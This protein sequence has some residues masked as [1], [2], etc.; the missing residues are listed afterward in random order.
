MSL[1]YPPTTITGALN[2]KKDIY[3]RYP[4]HAN[5]TYDDANGTLLTFKT[6]VSDSPYGN[7]EYKAF[8]NDWLQYTEGTSYGSNEWPA[9]G[10]F[11][12]SEG[13]TNTRLSYHN[14]SISMSTGSDMTNPLII[15]I[16]MPDHIKLT[17][18][19]MKNRPGFA[20]R[21]PKKWKLY[22]RRNCGTWTLIETRE[23]SS[24]S[25]GQTR[26]WNISPSEYYSD[27]RFDFLTAYNSS[28]QIYTIKLYG[29]PEQMTTPISFDRLGNLP[30]TR[31][32]IYNKATSSA[33]TLERGLKD[34]A[35]IENTTVMSLDLLQDPT[36][37]NGKFYV[38]NSGTHTEYFPS[39]FSTTP[40][41]FF[42]LEWEDWGSGNETRKN[43]V[44]TSVTTK[45]FTITNPQSNMDPIV[46][47]M[48][49][50]PGTGTIYGKNYK[51]EVVSSGNSWGTNRTFT[52]SS[53]MG[54]NP[55]AMYCVNSRNNGSNVY[56]TSLNAMPTSTQTTFCTGVNDEETVTNNQTVSSSEQLAY[57]VIQNSG[58]VT[59]KMY[60]WTG[61]EKSVAYDAHTTTTNGAALQNAICLGIV[62]NT[63]G[64]SSETFPSTPFTLG[65]D[66]S[67][68]EIGALENQTGNTNSEQDGIYEVSTGVRGSAYSGPTAVFDNNNSTLIQFGSYTGGSG[69]GQYTGS[70]DESGTGYLGG[71]VRIKMPIKVLLSQYSIT[72]GT[73]GNSNQ[74]PRNHA[75][76]GSN[77]NS[78]WT[79]LNNISGQTS[80]SNNQTKSWNISPGT[81]YQYYLYICNRIIKSNQHHLY[82]LSFV[83][84]GYPDNVASGNAGLTWPPANFNILGNHFDDQTEGR[85]IVTSSSV[86][87][88]SPTYME[89]YLAFNDSLGDRYLWYSNNNY[90]NGTYTGSS[91]ESGTGYL[92]EWLKIQ[93]PTATSLT[94]YTL[95]ADDTYF[96]KSPKDWKL[97]GSNDNSSWTAIDTQTSQT[98]TASESKNFTITSSSYLYFLFIFNKSASGSNVAVGYITFEGST[99]SGS[100]GSLTLYANRLTDKR[101]KWYIKEYVGRDGTH[102][103][104]TTLMLQMAGTITRTSKPL[105][106]LD[107]THL[108]AV[109]GVSANSQIDRWYNLSQRG[110]KYAVGRGS[111]KPTLKSD[112]NGYYVDFNYTGAYF[113][114]PCPITWKFADVD[115]VGTKGLTC[116]AVAQFNDTGSTT[117]DNFFDCCNPGTGGG[118]ASTETKNGSTYYKAIDEGTSNFGGTIYNNAQK[119]SG[120]VEL[121]PAS[122][123]QNGQIQWSGMNPGD[124]FYATFDTWTGS[125]S[126]ADAAWFYWGCTTRPTG[127]D[128]D[129]GGYLLAIDEYGTNEIQLEFNN[130]RLHTKVIGN[131]DDSAWHSW[132]V[133][134]KSNTIKVWRDTVL[135]FTK[136]DSSRTLS[137]LVGW[138]ARTGGKN[139]RH[140]VRNMKAW[141]SA[142]NGT[143]YINNGTPHTDRLLWGRTSTQ[144]KLQATDPSVQYDTTNSPA[145]VTHKVHTIRYNNPDKTSSIW[146][147]GTKLTPT[148][149]TQNTIDDRTTTRNVIGANADLSTSNMKLRELIVF[150]DILTDNQVSDINT[151]LGEKWGITF[152]TYPV[153][154]Q[155]YLVFRQTLGYLWTASQS[156]SLNSGDSSNDNYSILDTITDFQSTNG[157]YRLKYV[158]PANG[159]Y[160]D[161]RQTNNLTNAVQAGY[162]AVNVSHSTNGFNGL[163]PSG[164]TNKTRFDG[165][166]G[167]N[168]WYA[169]AAKQN[170][171][172]AFPGLD[173][174]HNVVEVYA[175][176][177]N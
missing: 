17:S 168:W 149:T 28:L 91:D 63:G 50:K 35:D 171:G 23:V 62:R 30:F 134:Y 5:V 119:K 123:S 77:D 157:T 121:T 7:G 22:G 70:E 136:V 129:S 151:S 14:T 42:T 40:G 156:L 87:H 174:V 89:P 51:C 86:K 85:Y 127:E 64:N 66:G 96:A 75:I 107:A 29:T 54:N 164:D 133:E 147:N 114:L 162:S 128:F 92:G 26:S 169:V 69:K 150:N 135:Q 46:H 88:L 140:L 94:Q 72:S 148:E 139:N 78:T 141:V 45:Y 108:N 109:Q 153:I 58:D 120:Y 55:Y 4:A 16:E 101:V 27:Y 159:N 57:L 98:Y 67:A 76:F 90:S 145:T 65:K 59:D 19:S 176:K 52:Y 132:I 68:R 122:N 74:A 165:T 12:K 154:G 106:H 31:T 99:G 73:N 61:T 9:N 43:L 112:S 130:S 25:S 84:E 10:P 33:I 21:S 155:W 116:F 18:Y 41:V 44:I 111:T 102:G 34:L 105:F 167:G 172:G 37:Y 104:E 79:S 95:Q 15:G 138:G 2:W 11:E 103:A 32:S 53:S 166:S 131:I 152:V 173:Y 160:N 110:F 144:L 146:T 49:V 124:R 163:G 80:W 3:D 39:E 38:P 126:G 158:N 177:E 115:G 113:D 1:E 175:M 82:K 143:G 125:G 13:D 161:W 93:F 118:G 83:G 56:N 100:P 170:H 24:W 8:G 47:W 117:S 142:N 71:W 36:M 97:F 81:A 48:A 137:T 60:M 20:V 6:V